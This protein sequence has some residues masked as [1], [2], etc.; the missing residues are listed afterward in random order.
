MTAWFEEGLS[1]YNN[2]VDKFSWRSP[3]NWDKEKRRS[4]IVSPIWYFLIVFG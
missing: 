2:L 3:G 1:M 4:D